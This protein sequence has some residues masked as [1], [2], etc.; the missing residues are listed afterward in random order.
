MPFLVGN[1]LERRRNHALRRSRSEEKRSTCLD[2]ARLDQQRVFARLEPQ[3]RFALIRCWR[4]RDVFRQHFL[5]VHPDRE[6]APA[7][8][9]DRKIHGT[10][11]RDFA[12]KIDRH[13]GVIFLAENLH[14]GGLSIRQFDVFPHSLLAIFPRI[15]ASKIN[16]LL[17]RIDR[18]ETLSARVLK[19]PADFPFSKLHLCR[20]GISCTDIPVKSQAV[21]SV[22]E[23]DVGLAV[24]VVI[25][26][27]RR[28]EVG[29]VRARQTDGGLAESSA[30]I[31]E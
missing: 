11:R 7:A 15:L 26:P 8:H 27:R 13:E 20:A 19:R 21:E 3:C 4:A 2:V 31:R 30:G 18:C 28:R 22:R 25:N 16:L 24:A 1:I 12:E 5:A 10:V 29:V 17:G 6:R 14:A 23:K 9:R